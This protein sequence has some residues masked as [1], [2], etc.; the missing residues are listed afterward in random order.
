MRKFTWRFFTGIHT[1]IYRLTK[2]RIGGKVAGLG[3]LLL[4]TAGRKSGKERTSPLD[5]M[6]DGENYVIIASNGGLDYHPGWYYN[7]QSNPR[8]Q[9]QVKDRLM[10]VQAETIQGEDR[11]RL[12]NQLIARAPVYAGY[13]KKTRREIPLVRL[14]P[15][16]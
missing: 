11:Q 9:I 16:S 14:T 5:Y 13:E 6:L 4:L 1:T 7:L 8:A 2:G 3:V 12:W 15:G 10:T